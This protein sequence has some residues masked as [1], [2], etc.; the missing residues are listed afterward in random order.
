MIMRADTQFKGAPVRPFKPGPLGFGHR[1][2]LLRAQHNM[3]VTKLGELLK[4]DQTTVSVWERESRLPR[5]WDIIEMCKLF[6]VSADWLLGIEA[7]G[8]ET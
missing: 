7:S 3:T 8:S 4:V 5:G 2:S 1:L 6:D